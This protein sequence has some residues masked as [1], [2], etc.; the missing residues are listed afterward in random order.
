MVSVVL[1]E[2]LDTFNPLRGHLL[3]QWKPSWEVAL[4][5]QTQPGQQ[6]ETA[7]RRCAHVQQDHC[8]QTGQRGLRNRRRGLRRGGSTARWCANGSRQVSGR[9]SGPAGSRVQ[10]LGHKGIRVQSHGGKSGARR[11]PRVRGRRGSLRGGQQ[12]LCS[13]IKKK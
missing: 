2:P 10:F 1:H 11:Q 7:Q 5:G 3:H 4:W 6:L 12:A 9:A 13:L 8:S